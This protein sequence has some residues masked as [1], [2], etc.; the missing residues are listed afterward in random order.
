MLA[1]L[2]RRFGVEVGD[3]W[4]GVISASL[5][6]LV[7][8]FT[9]R[10]LGGSFADSPLLLAIL[11]GLLIGNAFGLPAR[12][13]PGLRF[14]IRKILRL[15]VALVGFRVTVQQ[16]SEL[17]VLPFFLAALFLTLTFFFTLWLCRRVFRLDDEISTLLAAGCSIC[18]AAAILAV[19]AVTKARSQA[20]TVAVALITLLGTVSLFLYPFAFNAGLLP[21]FDETGYG[22]LTG[23][24]VFEVAQVVGAGYSVS[25]SAGNTAVVIKLSKVVMLVPLLV[26][27]SWHR[28]RR[29]VAA[30]SAPPLIPWFV[31]GFVGVLLVNSAGVV[32]APAVD[33]VNDLNL[34][35]LT[36]VMVALGLETRLGKMQA[37][38]WA[39]APSLA[40]LVVLVFVISIG[41]LGVGLAMPGLRGRMVSSGSPPAPAARYGTES[42][43]DGAALFES[44]GCAKCHVP[45]LPVA[46]G[47]IYLYSDLLLHDMG[48][49]L[50]DKT[51]QG[52]AG[53]SEW[54]TTPLWGLGLRDRYLHDGR[55]TTLRD[56]ITAHGGEA[57]IVKRRYL[58][59]DPDEEEA[60]R[61]F[62]ASL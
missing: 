11:L 10:G 62:L 15:S 24:T 8:L 16:V 9:S 7:A 30:V 55:A 54:R 19:A 32:P 23:A 59:L 39:L 48:P 44:I 18:G 3:R 2:K 28:R 51:V 43:S 52:D 12:L 41:V 58:Q 56:A 21:S 50:D 35:L 47:R 20:I 1:H 36:V 49:L 34:F 31:V 27:L 40:S 60:L 42:S 29:R 26:L 25:E 22:V 38:R 45:S 53:G 46:D 57:E 5:L 6:G 17:G 33:A 4:E 37:L 14:V 13:E 61:R